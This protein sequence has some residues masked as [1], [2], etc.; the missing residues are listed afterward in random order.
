MDLA[1]IVGRESGHVEA[2]VLAFLR[3]LQDKRLA[4]ET[5]S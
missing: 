3:Q 4:T 1:T 2:E 5:G